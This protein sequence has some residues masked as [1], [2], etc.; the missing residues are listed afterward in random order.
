[1]ELGAAAAKRL[2]NSAENTADSYARA[3]RNA[4]P[5]KRLAAAKAA[6]AKSRQEKGRLKDGLKRRAQA[7]PM[8]LR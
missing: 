4:E 1:M 3:I 7:G 2:Q 6:A 8:R 5:K